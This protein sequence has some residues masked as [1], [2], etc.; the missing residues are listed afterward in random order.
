MA[1]GWLRLYTELLDDPKIQSLPET[2]FKFWVNCLCLAGKNEGVI[3][4]DE[5]LAW[6]LREQ[7]CNV[8][9]KIQLLSEKG[10]I[11]ILETHR[12]PHNWHK[13]QY[14]SDNSTDRVRALRDKVKRTRNVPCNVSPSVSVSVSE[15]S[16]PLEQEK[17]KVHLSPRQNFSPPLETKTER[18]SEQVWADAGF[19]DF[20]DFTGWFEDLYRKHPTRGAPG[21]AKQGLMEA[22]LDRKVHRGAFES[23]YAAHCASR[24]WQK[25]RGAFIP[26]LATFVTDKGWLYPPAEIE[27]ERGEY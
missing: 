2:L 4:D 18:T 6:A 23:V 25:S 20:E 27:E 17:P 12:E 15:E 22:V 10:L 9:L 7:L 3:P 16:K 26:K 21:I 8:S 11:D 1:S 19:E 14:K 13:R 24:A 5:T